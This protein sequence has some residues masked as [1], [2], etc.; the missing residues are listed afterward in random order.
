MLYEECYQFF[1]NIIILPILNNS[2]IA[3]RILK[4]VEQKANYRLLFIFM[5]F[6]M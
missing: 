4:I 6:S 3:M 1:Q 5:N 2:D